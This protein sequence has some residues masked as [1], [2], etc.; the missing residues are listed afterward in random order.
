VHIPKEA[1]IELVGKT[2]TVLETLRDFPGGLSL[3]DLA[4]RTGHI[5]SSVHRILQS[6]KRH[7]YIEQTMLG[8]PY[9]LG[10]EVLILARNVNQGRN[11]LQLGHRYL[12]EL[13]EIFGETASLAILQK[14]QAFFVDIVEGTH[15]LRLASPLG[16]KA[17]FHATAAGKVI[18]A[19]LPPERQSLLLATLNLE[20]FTAKTITSRLHLEKE[21]AEI[22][23][24]G[25][26]VNN[27]ESF[28][29]GVFLAGPVFDSR[30]SIC[31]SIS[32]GIPK[33]RLS[34]KLEKKM[35][36][37]LVD[38]CSRLTGSLEATGYIHQNDF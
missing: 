9:R 23:Q 16:G 13:V 26:A 14:R 10:L 32:L 31:G 36:A 24:R 3:H 11:L 28:I 19:F 37:Q 17:Q 30:H 38:Y 8:G 7:G 21:W 20:P 35:A 18:A 29:G 33:S 4:L 1:Y 22:F 5:K 27:E 12:V 2:I 34:A 15:D 6:L 25:H